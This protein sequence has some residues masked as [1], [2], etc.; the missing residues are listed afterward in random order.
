MKARRSLC[1]SRSR[2][3]FLGAL[4]CAAVWVFAARSV[5]Q[6]GG[7]HLSWVREQGAEQ[8]IAG[9]ALE[10]ELA[11]A[12][13]AEHIE[14]ASVSI[15]GVVTRSEAE[16]VFRA[17]LRVLDALDRPVGL[18]E[19]VSPGPDCAALVPSLVLVLSF[20]VEL[21]SRSLPAEAAKQQA[22]PEL[23][24]ALHRATHAESTPPPAER[25]RRYLFEL[26]ASLAIGLKMNPDVGV[27]PALG[28]RVRTPLRL[29]LLLRA[30]YFPGGDTAIISPGA[31]PASVTFHS[32]QTDG[33][34]CF[35]ILDSGPW[36]LS[37]CLGATWLARRA[38]VSALD[39]ASPQTRS[40]VG[41]NAALQLAYAVSS[42]LF[43]G[44]DAGTAG[45]R[46]RDSY[47]VQDTQGDAQQVF[48]TTHFVGSF[49]LGLGVRL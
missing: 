49:A 40:L 27:G 13:A 26:S 14:K 15:E 42:R 35:P 7:F 43:V 31:E 25:D 32:V 16:G 36:W 47:V 21:S 10:S 34:L 6:Q 33:A 38:K 1:P 11:K 17:H 5:A 4:A 9:G 20:L 41:A 19:I 2:A 18:R 46:R 28:L 23:P 37:T 48:R 29:A 12:L 24:P 44:L 22:D 3:P 39:G 8:C 30:A 45:F